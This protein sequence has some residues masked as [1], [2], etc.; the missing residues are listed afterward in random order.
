MESFLAFLNLLP[1]IISTAPD[2]FSLVNR[3]LDLASTIK[4]EIGQE[5]LNKWMEETE[6]TIDQLK[7]SET[8]E[9]KRAVAANLV[10]LIRRL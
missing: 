7:K 1:K 4:K 2:V 6:K 8:P 10:N 9:Q 5:Q 3:L